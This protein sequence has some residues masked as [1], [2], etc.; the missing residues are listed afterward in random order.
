[1]L[2]LDRATGTKALSATTGQLMREL[3]TTGTKALSAHRAHAVQSAHRAHLTRATAGRTC[4]PVAPGTNGAVCVRQHQAAR[5][6]G[7]AR[8]ILVLGMGCVLAIATS[9]TR[10]YPLGSLNNAV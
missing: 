2:N 4:K 8:R 10:N 6:G 9:N 1:M 5:E 7:G 3:R